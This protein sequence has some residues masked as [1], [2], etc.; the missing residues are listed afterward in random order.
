MQNLNNQPNN[1]VADELYRIHAYAQ[2]LGQLCEL[3]PNPEPLSPEQL[4]VIFKDIA[5]VCKDSLNIMQN[6]SK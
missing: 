2:T 3:S 1:T 4:E 5:K 6:P